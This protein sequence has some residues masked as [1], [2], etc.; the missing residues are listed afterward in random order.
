ML[1]AQYFLRNRT[2]TIDLAFYLKLIKRK[3]LLFTH[4]HPQFTSIPRTQSIV[5]KYTYTQYL[6]TKQIQLK[7][8]IS[9]S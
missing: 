3:Q 7:N 8:T 2:K 6:F 4:L 1:T 9:E 5:N